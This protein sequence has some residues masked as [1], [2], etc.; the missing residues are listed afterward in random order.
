MGATSEQC[1]T[2]KCCGLSDSQNVYDNPE[3]FAGYS[4]MERFG[5]GWSLALEQPIFLSM[6]PNV[7]GLR[8]L[9]LGCGL[10]QLSY[11][12]ANAGAAEVVAVDI[13]QTML[14]RA[15]HERSHPHVTYQREAI[16]DLRFEPGRFG[17]IVSSLALHYVPNYRDLVKR[18]AMWLTPGGV[19][20]YS[21]EHPIYTARLPGEGWILDEHGQRVGW[22]ID[23][24]FHE[25]MRE[26]HW[27]V[28]GVRK[29]HRTIATLLDGLLDAGFRI[30]RVVEP[31]PDVD[32]LQLRPHESEHL[33]RPMFLLVR[34]SIPSER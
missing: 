16:E 17:L 24:Y 3:F 2:G 22:Q 21:T 25:G 15:R 31:A 28:E 4:Q 33:R 29:Y 8:V 26:E 5:A 10:G 32:R 7:Q 13:S 23:N 30:E 20:V 12:I 14:E 19:L 18:M 9:D 11:H 6:L 1:H 34:A 27:F